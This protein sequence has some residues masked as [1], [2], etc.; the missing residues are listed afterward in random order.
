M[1]VETL[2]GMAFCVGPAKG[3][4]PQEGDNPMSFPF[5]RYGSLM[6]APITNHTVTCRGKIISG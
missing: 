3:L 5:R 6:E 4:A 1:S 2:Q